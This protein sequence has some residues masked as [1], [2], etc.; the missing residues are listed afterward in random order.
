MNSILHISKYYHPFVGGTEQVARDAV[1]ALQDANTRQMIICF[2]ENINNPDFPCQRSATVR[3]R[4]DGVP[5]IRCG[6]FAKV[7]SQSVSFPYYRELKRI[8]EHF[9]PDTVIFHYPNP[10]VAHWLLKLKRHD[11][12]L[13]LYWHLDITRQKALKPFFHQQNI[14]LI[15]RAA[16]VVGATPMHTDQSAYSQYFQQKKA[17]IP[18]AINEERLTISKEEKTEA[19]RIRQKYP[20]V[21][22]CFFI[23]R[24]V[25]YKGLRH[26]VEASGLLGN[27][28]V[29]FLIA[30]DGELTEDLRERA[31]GDGKIEF[32][33]RIQDS[34][35]RA[36][37]YACDIFCFPSITRNEA[38]GLALAEGMYY[39]KPAVTFTIPGSGVNYV[40]LKGVTGIEC[41]NRDS[42][43]YAEAI[44][45]LA[46][47]AD[48][49]KT[50]GDNARKRVLDHFTYDQFKQNLCDLIRR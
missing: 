2:N 10:F 8:M 1:K 46:Q 22:L 47:N 17:V 48:L 18:Y 26:L 9:Q 38:F 7:A 19:E 16:Y 45:T 40:N 50:Y 44:L 37:L 14:A 20:G 23:G 36:Y 6:C 43:A 15:D 11:F 3:D 13:I 35:W 5:I 30:G 24:H 41:A 21:I 28:S 33:G 25:V 39:G 4:V 42:R 29:R 27:A 49:R 12:R 32:I 34:Q 31:K